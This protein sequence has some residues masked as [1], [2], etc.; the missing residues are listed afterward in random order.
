MLG[1]TGLGSGLGSVRTHRGTPPGWVL[2]E[3]GEG[4]EESAAEVLGAQRDQEGP[5]SL[6]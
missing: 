6:A 5:A 4:G 3:P 1:F 2:W